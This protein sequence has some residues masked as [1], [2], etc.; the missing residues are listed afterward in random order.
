MYVCCNNKSTNIPA[1]WYCPLTFTFCLL[2]QSKITV[3]ILCIFLQSQLLPFTPFLNYRLHSLHIIKN[4]IYHLP[5]TFYILQFTFYILYITYYLLLFTFYFLRQRKIM[6]KNDTLPFAYSR[7]IFAPQREIHFFIYLFTSFF[8]PDEF[9]H[10]CVWVTRCI[11]FT[12]FF[13]S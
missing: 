11:P 3:C 1:L 2:H 13:Q 4:S 12:R 8:L 9:Y 7:N 5:F 6:P 10:A